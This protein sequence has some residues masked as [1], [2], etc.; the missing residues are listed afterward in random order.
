MIQLTFQFCFQ[1]NFSSKFITNRIQL[2]LLF[3]NFWEKKKRFQSIYPTARKIYAEIVN[4]TFE[5]LN[6]FEAT[7]TERESEKINRMD[8]SF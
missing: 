4:R 8:K 2:G 6:L 3:G 5:M 7:E 1:A